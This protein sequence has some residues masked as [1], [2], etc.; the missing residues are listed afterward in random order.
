[1]GYLMKLNS[2]YQLNITKLNGQRGIIL[3][4]KLIPIYVLTITLGILTWKYR[5]ISTLSW[6]I[7]MQMF[8]GCLFDYIDQHSVCLGTLFTIYCNCCLW[9]WII[10][11]EYIMII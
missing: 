3:Q 9:I 4:G 5:T 8:I 2:N 11:N 7:N 6:T 10:C 1:M